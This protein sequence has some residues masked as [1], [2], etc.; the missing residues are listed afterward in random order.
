MIESHINEGRQDVPPAGPSALK[1]GVSITDACVD[2]A[3][4][5]KMLDQ[6]DQVRSFF[7]FSFLRFG[8][9]DEGLF[10]FV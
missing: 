2:W 9:S 3:S 5:V 10:D 6:L 7:F 8:F 4:T 1:H